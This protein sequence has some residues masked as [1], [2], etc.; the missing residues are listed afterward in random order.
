MQIKSGC[1]WATSVKAEISHTFHTKSPH[2]C[3]KTPLFLIHNPDGSNSEILKCGTA[4]FFLSF[5]TG[6]ESKRYGEKAIKRAENDPQT[7]KPKL[8]VPAASAL[9]AREQRRLP[10]PGSEMTAHFSTLD[11]KITTELGAKGAK[12][13]RIP[14]NR[15]LKHLR[16]TRGNVKR[17]SRRHP[18]HASALTRAAVGRTEHTHTKQQKGVVVV[19]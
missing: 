5:S 19:G 11:G 8:K 10:S 4:H 15:I 2:K 16:D 7:S 9:A 6:S 1:D 12:S 17:K 18:A 14:I 3:L 13:T